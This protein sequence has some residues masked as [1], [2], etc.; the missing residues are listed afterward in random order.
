MDALHT[1]L[2]AYNISA[3]RIATDDVDFV[4]PIVHHLQ[5]VGVSSEVSSRGFALRMSNATAFLFFCVQ[6]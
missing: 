4:Q 1:M 6:R 3:V 2:G 5:G